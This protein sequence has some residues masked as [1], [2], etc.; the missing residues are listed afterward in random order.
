MSLLITIDNGG[1]FTDACLT[2]GDKVYHTKTLTTPYDLSECFVEVLRRAALDWQESVDLDKFLAEVEWIRYSSTV[3]TNAL[4]QRKGPRLGLIVRS[5]TDLKQFQTTLKAEELWKRLVGDQV[6]AVNIVDDS[7][8]DEATVVRAVNQL[9]SAGANR[10]VVSLSDP[11][12]LRDEQIIKRIILRKFPRHMLGAVPVLYSHE[13]AVDAND[14]RR[15]WTALFNSFLHP[16]VERFLF[17]AQEIMRKHHARRPLL[18]FHN[19]GNSARVAKTVALKTYSSGPRGGLEGARALAQ[20]YGWPRAVTMDV[21]GTTTDFG[22]V[23]EG[24][25][26]EQHFGTIEGVP[27]AINLL[28]SHSIGAGGSSVISAS[29]RTVRIGPDSMGALPGPACFGRGGEQPT[30]TDAWLTLG[31][32]DPQSF[33][34]GQL[35][36][37]VSRAREALR[38]FVAEPLG[39]SVDE[40]AVKTR[41]QFERTLADALPPSGNGTVLLGFGGAGPLCACGVA[42]QADIDTVVIPRLAA[43]FSAFGISFSDIAHTYDAV[44]GSPK[45]IP[46]AAGELQDRA[47]RDMFAE[48]FRLE[49]CELRW[50]I[51]SHSGEEVALASNPHTLWDTAPHQIEPATLRLHVIAKIDHFQ[52]SNP[53]AIQPI[54]A[55]SQSRRSVINPDT[56]QREDILVYQAADLAPGATGIG[57]AVIEDRYYTCYVPKG[58]Q[59]DINENRDITLTHR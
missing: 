28:D 57:S 47:Q 56:Y 26:I 10:L 48:G 4:V 5:G 38:R 36:L 46:I 18:I 39:L 49:A 17:N 53:T 8:I 34:G 9:L 13:L 19:D 16:E 42:E 52:L 15:T 59:F 50:S 14:Y 24:N 6:I 23:Q 30:V 33:F 54:K 37:D 32:F 35:T 25:I 20:L 55:V 22:L 44:V 58:W 51:R 29:G 1:T 43:V 2:N 7:T 3:G 40:A 31:L 12:R 11:H 27:T 45:E 21:G 41:E